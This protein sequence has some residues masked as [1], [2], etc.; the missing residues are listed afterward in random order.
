MK[1]LLDAMYNGLK[2]YLEEMGWQVKTVK[3]LGKPNAKDPEVRSYAE[4]N[5]FILVTQDKRSADVARRSGIERVW[6]SLGDI[7]DLVK[8]RII[9]GNINA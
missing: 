5:G 6:V 3:D 2:E 8:E 4:E 9:T 1:I 7:V